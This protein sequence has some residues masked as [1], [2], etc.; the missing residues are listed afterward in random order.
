[1]FKPKVRLIAESMLGLNLAHYGNILDADSVGAIFIVARLDRQDVPWG[2][3]DVNVLLSRPDAD[4]SLMNVQVRSYSMTCS[5]P[6]VEAS[7]LLGRVRWYSRR[8]LPRRTYPE[9]LAGQAINGKTSCALREYGRVQSDVALQH[10]GI[11]SLFG[12]RWR[13]KMEGSRGVCGTV[14][15]LC[16]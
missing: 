12:L 13:P 14:E 7:L 15:I 9:E 11:G 4:G 3:G 10:K 8:S 16:P 6:V 2:K 1:M 5:V